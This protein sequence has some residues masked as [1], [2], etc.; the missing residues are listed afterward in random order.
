[1]D[2]RTEAVRSFTRH[3]DDLPSSKMEDEIFTKKP[4]YTIALLVMMAFLLVAGAFN[5]YSASGG[6]A[7]FTAH[8]KHMTLGLVGFTMLVFFIQPKHLSASTYWLYGLICA[9]LVAVLVMG[10]VGGGS[11]RWLT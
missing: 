4:V 1:M 3:L 2:S 11:R 9:L 7:M 10:H 6:D 8:M 5:I